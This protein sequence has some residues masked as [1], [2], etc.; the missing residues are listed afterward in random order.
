MQTQLKDNF[1]D[2][3]KFSEKSLKNVWDNPQDDLWNKLNQN[4]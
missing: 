4:C 3:I 1:K 2:I